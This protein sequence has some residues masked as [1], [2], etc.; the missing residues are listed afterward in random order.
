MDL[1]GNSFQINPG[2]L[3]IR[4]KGEPVSAPVHVGLECWLEARDCFDGSGRRALILPV[5]QNTY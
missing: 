1:P 4:V 5:S 2:V 3:A